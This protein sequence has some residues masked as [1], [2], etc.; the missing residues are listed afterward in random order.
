MPVDL[1]ERIA[2]DVRAVVADPAVA[3]TVT[4]TGQIVSPGSPTEFARAIEEQLAAFTAIAKSLDRQP[5]R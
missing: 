4:G 2:A 1:R 5:R 3:A